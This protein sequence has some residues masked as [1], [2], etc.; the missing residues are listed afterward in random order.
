MI[1]NIRGTSGSGKSYLVRRVLRCYTAGREIIRQAG[2]TQPLAYVYRH[3]NGSSLAVIG[4]Y[5][6]ECG[7]CDTITDVRIVF[8]M[9]MQ[10]HSLG[11]N[12]L[13]EGLIVSSLV[14]Q[15]VDI[16]DSTK[17]LLVISLNTPLED[18]LD[19]V[20]RRR[21]FKAPARTNLFGVRVRQ[22]EDVNPKN[23]TAKVKIVERAM[24]RFS[25]AGVP[26]VW[27]SREQAY[28]RCKKELGL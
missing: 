24:E 14:N 10:Y 15:I 26:C 25:E 20:N 16:W 4:H 8:G 9:V 11:H 19:S 6:Q 28:N 13:F 3:T 7:G 12:V 18:C 2:R 27:L 21:E 23:T 22:T 17:A 5:E 1:L